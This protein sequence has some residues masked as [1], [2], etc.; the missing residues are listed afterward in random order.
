MRNFQNVIAWLGV[1]IMVIGAF[2]AFRDSAAQPGQ[3][4]VTFGYMFALWF[5]LGGLALM[6]AFGLPSKPRFFWFASI[7][8]GLIYIVSFFGMYAHLGERV[9]NNQVDILMTEL[10]MSVLPGLV[11][12]AEGIWLKSRNKKRENLA[13]N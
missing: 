4:G 6:L 3:I 13:D 9:E 1:F 11:A 2:F 5:G 8:V 7:A 10:A 12:I